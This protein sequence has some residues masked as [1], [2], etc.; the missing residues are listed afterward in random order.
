M[1]FSAI[2]PRHGG[3]VPAIHVFPIAVSIPAQSAHSAAMDR[4]MNYSFWGLGL[5]IWAAFVLA[6]YSW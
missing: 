1:L 3:L 2:P 5:L 6:Y 4:A